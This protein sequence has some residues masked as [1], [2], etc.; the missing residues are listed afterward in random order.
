MPNVQKAHYQGEYCRLQPERGFKPIIFSL[1]PYVMRF[2]PAYGQD[3]TE[4]CL[5]LALG[6][7]L[8]SLRFHHTAAGLGVVPFCAQTALQ[9]QTRYP[10]PLEGGRLWRS[11]HA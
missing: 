8:Q 4:E 6:S 10:V 3:N 9:I 1:F 5:C 11:S 2:L 7:V